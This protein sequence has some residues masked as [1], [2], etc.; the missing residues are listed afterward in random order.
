MSDIPRR[1]L[2]ARELKLLDQVIQPFG[3][4]IRMLVEQSVNYCHLQAKSAEVARTNMNEYRRLTSAL[5]DPRTAPERLIVVGQPGAHHSY[6]PASAPDVEGVKHALAEYDR[7]LEREPKTF[8]DHFWRERYAMSAMAI[9]QQYMV[10]EPLAKVKGGQSAFNKYHTIIHDEMMKRE[11][12]EVYA[13]GLAYYKQVTRGAYSLPAS[14]RAPVPVPPNPSTG[15]HHTFTTP[16]FISRA[17]AENVA[18]E[19][20]ALAKRQFKTL[21]FEFTDT[22]GPEDVPDEDDDVESWM[23]NSI[24]LDPLSYEVVFLELGAPIPHTR[25]EL[26]DLLTSSW[27]A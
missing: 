20:L 2:T 23:V 4:T 25:E 13:K 17:E 16:P 22:A 15:G 19:I 11:F 9:L 18:D 24:D 27:P 21:K 5:L 12:P 6:G 26:I 1:Q 3:K 7:Y 10:D 8:Q 14:S